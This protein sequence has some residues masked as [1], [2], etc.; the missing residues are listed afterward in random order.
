MKYILISKD[1]DIVESFKSPEAFLP[2]DEVLAFSDWKEALD[3]TENADL[4]FVDMVATLNEPH[5]I[6]GY[7]QFAEAKMD[8]PTA[9]KV[10]LVLISLPEGYEIDFLTGYPDFVF[11]HMPHPPTVKLF[12]RASTWV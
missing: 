11:A 12:R 1:P 3:A 10:P 7:E 2:S 9:G 4:L 8:H 5:K 6:E